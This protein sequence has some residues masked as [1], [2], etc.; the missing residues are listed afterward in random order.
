LHINKPISGNIHITSISPDGIQP[1]ISSTISSNNNNND[2]RGQQQNIRQETLATVKEKHPEYFVHTGDAR[3]Q[4]PIWHKGKLLFALNVGCFINGDTQSRSCIRII[5]F[6]TNTSKVLL[7]VNI[8]NLGASLYYP[9]LSIDKSGDNM[10]IIFGYSSSNTYPSLLISSSSV[11]N[12]IIFNSKYFQFLKDGTA[13][14]LSTRYGDYFSAVM[15]PSEPNTIWVA[16]Q[17][18]YYYYY[19]SSSSSPLLWSTYIGKINT[20]SSKSSQ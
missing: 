17:Y 7:D 19:Y 2:K 20:E 8:G 18:Y 4:S 5:E 9:A 16:G 6:D 3:M 11:K 1:I 14:S 10:G 13:N 12:N 15:D